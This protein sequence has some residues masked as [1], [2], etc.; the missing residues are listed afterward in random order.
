MNAAA[1]VSLDRYKRCRNN[2]KS[3]ESFITGNPLIVEETLKTLKHGK[4]TSAAG[5][6]MPNSDLRCPYCR[7]FVAK[8]LR[9]LKSHS[10]RSHKRKLPI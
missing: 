6:N 3:L 1:C 5:Q 7:D 10:R 8:S 4:D 9:G 2:C